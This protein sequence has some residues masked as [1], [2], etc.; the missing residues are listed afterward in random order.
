MF[1]IAALQSLIANA[2]RI[3]RV[4]GQPLTDNSLQFKSKER[5]DGHQRK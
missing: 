3:A 5:L 2:A 4:A 1:F